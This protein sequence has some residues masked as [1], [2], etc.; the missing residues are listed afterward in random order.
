MNNEELYPFLWEKYNVYEFSE[1]W[2]QEYKEK[3][4]SEFVKKFSSDKKF[5]SVCW[6]FNCQI[7][8]LPRKK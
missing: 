6:T 8:P 5:L 2:T 3:N 1:I 7:S 4:D